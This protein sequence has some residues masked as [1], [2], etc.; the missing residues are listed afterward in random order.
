MVPSGPQGQ[1]LAGVRHSL[2][3]VLHIIGGVGA[4]VLVPAAWLAPGACLLH[5]LPLVGVVRTG[6]W[7]RGAALPT[8][9]L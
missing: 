4:L 1:A 3:T 8:L 2:S 7:S 5:A 6:L 9:T